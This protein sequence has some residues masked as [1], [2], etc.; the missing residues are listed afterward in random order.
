ML[1]KFNGQEIEVPDDFIVKCGEHAEQR[2]MTLEE[3]IAEAFTMY[4]NQTE[5]KS[6]S[7]IMQEELEPITHD[8]YAIDQMMDEGGM[9]YSG[10]F[11]SDIE[12]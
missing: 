6:E 1:F 8:S 10:A 11:E 3:Y 12:E 5:K 4:K 9:D 7:E 2:G